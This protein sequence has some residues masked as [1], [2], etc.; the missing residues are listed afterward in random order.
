MKIGDIFNA[1]VKYLLYFH[2]L[3]WLSQLFCLSPSRM[4]LYWAVTLR[5]P[6]AGLEH[7]RFSFA[8]RFSFENLFLICRSFL[9]LQHVWWWCMCLYF[10]ALFFHLH[11]F[12]RFVPRLDLCLSL[13]F[14]IVSVLEAVFSSW[15]VL[16]SCSLFDPFWPPYISLHINLYE[17]EQHL[18]FSNTLLLRSYERF[19]IFTLKWIPS[20]RPSKNYFVLHIY[21]CLKRFQAYKPSY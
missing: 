18:W 8:D 10:A 4:F 14:W 13:W 20:L 9:Y 21:A 12:P 6:P 7:D 2:A 16:S 5:A 1:E 15:D 17:K 3:L 11:H 19:Q